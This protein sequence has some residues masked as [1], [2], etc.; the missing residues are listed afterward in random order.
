MKKYIVII[1]KEA[2]KWRYVYS[3]YLSSSDSPP[4][5]S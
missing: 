2:S 3:D 4:F 1:A 5:E